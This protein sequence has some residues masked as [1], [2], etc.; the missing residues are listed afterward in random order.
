MSAAVPKTAPAEHANALPIYLDN[1]A[2]TPL[3]PRALGA[4]MPY[5][6]EHF[7]NPHSE[8]HVYGRNAM[9]A[10]DAARAEIARLIGAD[11]REITFTSGATEANNLAIKGVA[12]FA[13]AHTPA[14]GARD[15]VV[16]LTTEHKCV[17]ESCAA[18]EREG[19]RVT[20][21]PVEPGGLLSLDRLAGALDDRTLLVSIMAAH[22]EIGVI[23]PLSEIGALCRARGVLFHTDA[24][25]AAGKIPLD[26]EAMK[27]DLMSISSHK[28]YGPKGIGALYVRRRPRVRLL[29]L[30]DGGGQERGLRSGT[31]P[32]PLCIGFGRAAALAAA[33]MVGE[34]ARIAGLRDRLQQNLARRVPGIVVN[35]DCEHRLAGNLNLSFPG[36]TA[37]ELI[38]ACP[39]IAISTGSACTSAAVEPSYVLRALGLSDE[40]A[41]ASIRIGIGRFNTAADVDFAVDALAAAVARLTPRPGPAI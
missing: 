6:T 24:A 27:I 21:L 25:Q 15:H 8:S 30:I 11:P 9:A 10:I 5:F 34:A 13:R 33:E 1:Q 4:M 41:N 2:S 3:D 39:S 29:P 17:L 22:N 18:L 23:Q 26:V 19:F 36:L 32:T 31:L 16:A 20:Y 12:H 28:L 35:G 38:E 7:G 40:R 14:D 37:P